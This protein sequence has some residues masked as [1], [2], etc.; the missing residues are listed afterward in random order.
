MK[1]SKTVCR[2]VHQY[3]KEPVPAEDMG[4]LQEIAE[5]YRQVKNYVYTRYG[6]T[7][8]LSKLYPGYTVQNEMTDSGLRAEL[9][10]PPCISTVLYST[11][12]A[13]SRASGRGQRQR[14]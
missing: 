8:S 4:K 11:H 5:D 2:T 13:I 7:G 6:G 9:S 1:P 10:L 3:N 14:S 12:S